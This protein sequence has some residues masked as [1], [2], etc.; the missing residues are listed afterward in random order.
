MAPLR[1]AILGPGMVA[2]YHHA[3]LQAHADASVELAAVVHHNPKRFSAISEAF[4]VPCVSEVDMLA[5]S[6]IDA[7]ILCTPSGQH[8]DQ[9]VAAAQAGK[10]VLVE[11]PLATTL[12]DADRMIAA[13]EAAGV[14]LGVVFQRRGLPTFQR[15]HQALAAGDLGTL[16]MGTLQMPYFRPQ[17]YYDQAAWRGTWALDGGGVL[18]NQGIHLIDLLVW[19]MGDPV[20]VSASGGALQWAID[21]EDTVAATLRF[22]NGSLATLTATTTAAPGFTHKL[23]LYGTLGGI[24]IE[25]ER[26][27]S[28][29]YADTMTPTV[30]PPEL[31]KDT[32]AGSGA[33][34]K[35]IKPTG[36]IAILSDF[37]RAIREDRM[38]LVDG[39]EGR[40]SL[41]TI[42]AI[43]QAAGLRP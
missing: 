28:W 22:A 19:Y 39:A 42:L 21:V 40:R 38:P 16:T 3:A 35:G 36:H 5:D 41:A 10:H 31:V 32:D 8:A 14:K 18:M 29:R 20:E 17:S 1:F 25:G 13:C 12:A 6:S 34:P 30:A 43:Y 4:G 2:Q 15:V 27:A 7:V 33:D 24:E 9:A 23:G 37:I 26:I 11:K